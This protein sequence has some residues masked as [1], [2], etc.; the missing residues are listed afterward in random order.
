MAE[1]GLALGAM[2]LVP[3]MIAFIIMALGDMM[4]RNG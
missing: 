3:A 4:R 1:L 2:L